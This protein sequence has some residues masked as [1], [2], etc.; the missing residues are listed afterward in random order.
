MELIQKIKALSDETRMRILSILKE[1]DLCVSEI[2]TVLNISQ[3]NVSRH[4]NKLTTAKIL[5][6]YKVGQ[7]VYYKINEN[8]I[9]EYPFIKE[10]IENHS[11]KIK[12]CNMDFEKLGVYKD[13]LR[14]IVI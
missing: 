7:Y 9:R 1:S 2:E 10:I 14:T 3:S 8:T 5:D 4:L 12:Q 13:S 6:Y 11:T